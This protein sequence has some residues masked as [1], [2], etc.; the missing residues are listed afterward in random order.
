MAVP[1]VGV[2]GATGNGSGI[3]DHHASS[4]PDADPRHDAEAENPSECRTVRTRH[5]VPQGDRKDR[6]HRDR[7]VLADGEP[8]ESERGTRDQPPERSGTEGDCTRGKPGHLERERRDVG[9]VGRRQ[10]SPERT[11]RDREHDQPRTAPARQDFAAEPHQRAEAAEPEQRGE[12]LHHADR[13]AEDRDDRS[14]QDQLADKGHR[15]PVV[16]VQLPRVGPTEQRDQVRPV[17]TPRHPER[18][19]V[20]HDRDRHDEADEDQC[21]PGQ[22]RRR[23]RPAFDLATGRRGSVITHSSDSRRR[24]RSPARPP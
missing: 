2:E 3:V 17:V 7:A 6:H 10:R 8:D 9:H 12:D 14:R 16:E 23:S 20:R 11:G 22:P 15:D 18:A 1:S 13:V 4:P 5:R 19:G 21:D 24:T